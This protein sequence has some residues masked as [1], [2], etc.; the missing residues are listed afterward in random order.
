MTPR[1]LLGLW[2]DLVQAGIVILAAGDRLRF[3]PQ[4]AMTDDL[5]QRVK[6]FKRDLLMLLA[7]TSI[8]KP[9]FQ[10]LVDE[11]VD[12]IHQLCPVGY[13][14]SE[15]DWQELNLIEARLDDSKHGEGLAT[16]IA[17]AAEYERKFRK[18]LRRDLPSDEDLAWLEYW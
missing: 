7:V 17:A 12:R 5:L 9:L 13:G 16:A 4:A 18:F 1:L 3:R 8:T 2:L 11:L 10:N 14:L 6:V 15:A